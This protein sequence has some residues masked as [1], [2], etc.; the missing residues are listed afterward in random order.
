MTYMPPDIQIVHVIKFFIFI[1]FIIF[2][3]CFFKEK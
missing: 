1:Y 3:F 2:P